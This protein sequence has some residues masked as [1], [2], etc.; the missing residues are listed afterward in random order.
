M[1]FPKAEALNLLIK[2]QK[3]WYENTTIT[4]QY[5]EIVKKMDLDYFLF[6]LKR[7]I[8]NVENGKTNELIIK[9]DE[10]A[11]RSFIEKLTL[12]EIR[13]D[14]FDYER[15][16][17]DLVM[18]A[19]MLEEGE[20]NIKIDQYFL[21]SEKNEIISESAIKADRNVD[22]LRNWT[23]KFPSIEIA[24]QSQFS[25]LKTVKE[26]NTDFFPSETLSMI[27]TAIYKTVLPTNFA[28]TE[29]HISRELPSYSEAGYESKINQY[30]NMDLVFTNPNNEKY[31][32]EFKM[33][34][35]LFYVSLKGASFAYQYNVKT[36]DKQFFKPKTIIQ[37]SAQLPFGKKI[38]FNEG[39]DGILVKVIR[40]TV[41]RN[42]NVLKEEKISE[43][44]YP[45][46]PK[47]ISRSSIIDESSLRKNENN[48]T[49]ENTGQSPETPSVS[50]PENAD[51]PTKPSVPKSGSV[52]K[53][54]DQTDK[55]KEKENENDLRGKPNETEK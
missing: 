2:K 4:F 28:I 27:A 20:H 42:G 36:E 23:E 6:D 31:L 10:E 30:K 33:I 29:R 38:T 16:I 39:K 11:L 1:T 14:E 9:V 24:P 7:S 52:E 35:N 34:G 17:H 32:L 50:K 40:E 15:F 47:V 12:R 41:D 3:E 51:K 37:Y 53:P 55:V 46:I 19:T 45:P 13:A 25:I 5:K 18:F 21:A 54:S 26:R 43:D 48:A 49:D 44:F 8:D 22:L